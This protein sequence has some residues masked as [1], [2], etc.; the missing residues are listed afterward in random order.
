MARI[1]KYEID[2]NTNEYAL[3]LSHTEALAFLA[4]LQPEL[5]GN[6]N[7]EDE[8][9]LTQMFSGTFYKEVRDTLGEK[10]PYGL[11]DDDDNTV[12]LYLAR[13]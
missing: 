3:R 13:P 1:T 12:D 6:L 5:G 8:E 9:A 7:D 2:D 4:I 10:T 11:V